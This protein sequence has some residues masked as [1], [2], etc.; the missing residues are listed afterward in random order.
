MTGAEM[1]FVIGVICVCL[2]ALGGCAMTENQ[3]DQL[4]SHKVTM[5]A[6]DCAI[7]WEAERSDRR[8]NKDLNITP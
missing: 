4:N 8:G 5:N 6:E 7:T 1:A 2:S 3:D